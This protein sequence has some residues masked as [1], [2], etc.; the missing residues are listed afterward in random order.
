[1]HPSM[2]YCGIKILLGKSK[3]SQSFYAEG[4]E[5]RLNDA[6]FIQDN[7][8][9]GDVYV[10]VGANI[11]TLA[12]LAAKK[13]GQTGL[14]IAIEAHPRTFCEMVSNIQYNDLN[15]LSVLNAVGDKQAFV[16][17]SD[18]PADDQNKVQ[19]NGEIAIYMTRLDSLLPP[20]I[21]ERRIGLLKIDVEG[22]EYFVLKGA[23]GVLDRVDMIY[24]EI[25]ESMLKSSGVTSCQL[26][27]LL[28]TSGFTVNYPNGDA[29]RGKNELQFRKTQNLVATRVNS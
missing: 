23:A 20:L 4:V 13:V 12:L 11:G 7:L 16:R 22:Y 27:D 17:F 28:V 14:C 3:L 29:L 9:S 24:F 18:D 21:G 25:S 19:E 2:D 10:D 26:L 1:M 8:T 15:V 6:R 5:Q